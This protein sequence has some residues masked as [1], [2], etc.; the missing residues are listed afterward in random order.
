MS[1]SGTRAV[2]AFAPTPS[3]HYGPSAVGDDLRRFFNLTLTLATTDFKLRYFGSALGYLWS[4]VR[5]LLFFGVLY[6]MFTKILHAGKGI[7]HY[8]VYLLTSIMLW[9]FFA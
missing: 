9:T 7:A 1:S 2:G 4:L 5:P 3:R 6:V 8:E